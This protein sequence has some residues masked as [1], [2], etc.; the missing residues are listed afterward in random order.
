MRAGASSITSTARPGKAGDTGLL[1]LDVPAGVRRRRRRLPPRG[2]HIRGAGAPG[3]SGFGQ[4]VHSIC[5]H[6]VLNHGTEEQKT[7][8]AAAAGQRRAD[9]RHRHDRTAARFRPKGI[10]TRAVREGDHYVVNGSKIFIT[11]GW[12]A[13]L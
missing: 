11:N 2:R 7:T 4:G 13:G 8:L 3:L 5:A 6:Y 12:L 9:R 10:R 1:C